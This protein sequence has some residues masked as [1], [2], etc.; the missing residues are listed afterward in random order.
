MLK[1]N[2][3][4]EYEAVNGPPQPPRKMKKRQNAAELKKM[5]EQQE[6]DYK[7]QEAVAKSYELYKQ[8]KAAR[9]AK[10]NK[11]QP[12]LSHGGVAFVYFMLYVCYYKIYVKLFYPL[13]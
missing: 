6:E 4:D 8:Q 2:S 13:S 7:R 3:T 11:A 1:V 12:L 9:A 5:R 10:K